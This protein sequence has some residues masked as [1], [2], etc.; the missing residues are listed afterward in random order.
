M[1]TLCSRFPTEDLRYLVT[2]AQINA[3]E[4]TLIHVLQRTLHCYTCPH[5]TLIELGIPPLISQQALQSVALHFRYMVL[6]SN[7]KASKLDNLRYKFR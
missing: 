7:T 6:H 4:R 1:A 3:I 5:F 2:I